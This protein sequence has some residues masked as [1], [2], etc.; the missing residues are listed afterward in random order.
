MIDVSIVITNYNKGSLLERAVRSAINQILIRK[1]IEVIIVDDASTDDSLDKFSDIHDKLR[2]VKHK[3]NLGV[4]AAS[5]TGI[6]ESVGKYW[7]RVDAD[8]YLSQ[9]SVQYMS[10]IL[11]NN[12]DIGFVYA[13]HYLI[14]SSMQ[15]PKRIKLDTDEKLLLHGAGVMFRRKILKEYGGYDKNLR[16]GEDFDLIARMIKGGVKSHYIPLPLYRYY[17]QSEGLTN[18]EDR[19]RIIKSLRAKYGF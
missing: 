4:S 19:E 14:N 10:A 11:D 16:N 17:V 7:M 15:K 18:H 12:K 9:M 6:K 8:D 5:N 2:I 1:T 13:D 3:K